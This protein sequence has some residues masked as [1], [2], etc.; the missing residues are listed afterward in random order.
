[1][2][3]NK[4]L[5]NHDLNSVSGGSND[6]DE[7]LKTLA[8]E[9]KKVLV[10]YGTGEQLEVDPSV[11]QDNDGNLYIVEREKKHPEIN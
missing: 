11:H 5:N 7:Y 1:M 9:S 10:D 8:E 3:S 4:E 2:K 6:L